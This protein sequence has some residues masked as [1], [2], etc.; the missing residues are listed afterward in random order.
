MTVTEHGTDRGVIG[1]TD[2]GVTDNR[3]EWW[4]L[5]ACLAADPDL[6]F[7]ISE[8]GPARQQ[9]TAAKRVCAGCQVR[10]QCLSYALATGPIQGVWGGTSEEE[11]RALARAEHPVRSPRSLSAARRPKQHKVARAPRLA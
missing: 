3:A 4:S 2:R 5:G 11:R 1:H 8:A 7:P 9:V 6:F 10:E